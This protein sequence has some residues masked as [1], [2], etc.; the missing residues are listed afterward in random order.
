M[1][2]QAQAQ[3]SLIASLQSQAQLDTANLMTRY[4]TKLALAN[5]G[6]T[7]LPTTPPIAA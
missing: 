6:M 5:S 7:A 4:G 1:A 2:E 3:K